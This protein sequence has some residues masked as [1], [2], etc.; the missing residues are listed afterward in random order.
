MDVAFVDPFAES[1]SELFVTMLSSKATRGEPGLIE[2]GPINKSVVALIGLSGNV[3]GTVAL[4]LPE[5]TAMNMVGRMLGQKLET[6][7][8]TTTDGIAEVVNMI[9]GAAKAKFTIQVDSEPLQLSLPTVLSGSEYTVERHSD[10]KWLEIPYTSDLGAF[11][12]RV[13][14]ENGKA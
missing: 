14:F 10:V 1:V 8:S 12:L 3:K 5:L 4:L 9:A 6:F 7:D 2:D 11:S 13:A